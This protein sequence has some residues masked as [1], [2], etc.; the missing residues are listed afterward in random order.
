MSVPAPSKTPSAWDKCQ[1]GPNKLP[2]FCTVSVKISDEIT[3]AKPKGKSGAST[4]F[5]G[6]NLGTVKVVC[7]LPDEIEEGTVDFDSAQELLSTLND[8]RGEHFEIVHP[9]TKL[10]GIKTVTIESIT[11]DLKGRELVITFE[12]SEF[13]EPKKGGASETKTSKTLDPRNQSLAA[14]LP[15]VTPRVRPT[16]LP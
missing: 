1:L 2:G 14:D 4:T 7:S 6:A 5:Q 10:F 16:A 3:K 15:N 9:M 13:K 11:G 8:K 12:L